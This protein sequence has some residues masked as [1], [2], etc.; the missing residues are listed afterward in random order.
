MPKR[1]I[2]LCHPILQNAW[3]DV[4][5]AYLRKY[6]SLPKPILTATYRSNDEQGELYKKGRTMG[7]KIVTNIKKDGKHNNMP[8]EAFDIAFKNSDGT[9]DWS[10]Q[11]FRNF[12]GI[13]EMMYPMVVWGGS[14]KSFKDLPHFEV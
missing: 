7:G 2:T 10:G 3:C 1:D 14:W 11:N 5:E 13:M 8:A 6:P 4:S 12:A 9:L